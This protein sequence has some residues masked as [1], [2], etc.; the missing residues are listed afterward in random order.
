MGPAMMVLEVAMKPYFSFKSIS[1]VCNIPELFLVMGLLA[2][3]PAIAPAQTLTTLYS[4][5]GFPNDGLNPDSGLVFDQQ[6]NLYGTTFSGGPWDYCYEPGGCGTVFNLTP[7]GKE[8][9]LHTFGGSLTLP[10][11][12]DG[13]NPEGG[14]VVDARGNLYG[15]TYYG[16]PTWL[17][18][19]NLG[20][21]VIYELTPSRWKILHNFTGYPDDGANPGAGMISDSYGNF[22]G[23]TWAGGRSLCGTVF[24]LTPQGTETVLYNFKCQPKDG[25]NPDSPLVF[26]TQGNLYGTTYQGGGFCAS[27]GCGS[28]FKL[29]PD[30]TE[31][32]L[33]GFMG[34]YDGIWPFGGLIFDAAGNLYGTTAYGGSYNAN[35]QEW[36]GGCG[37]VFKLAPD[38]TKT[39]LY[40]FAGGADGYDPN[41]GLVMDAQGNLYGA[42]Y[43]GGASGSN[44]YGY[45]TIFKITPAGA[46]TVLYSFCSQPN[47]ADGAYPDAPLVFDGQGNLYG[48]TY[49]GGNAYYGTVFKLSLN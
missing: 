35:C 6:G 22:Y 32:I 4:F 8:T 28:V 34:G 31:T 41:G 49:R 26:D 11:R 24:Q 10:R 42:T 33:W 37:T 25:A 47:C 5:A 17:G 30:G 38:G 12:I 20:L 9:V 39:I 21:G 45:G 19:G 43:M 36:P 27:L 23:T 18:D 14:V 40:E 48:T 29:A 3:L 16:G 1:S 2:L 15:T 13:A 46:E 7:E 44:T